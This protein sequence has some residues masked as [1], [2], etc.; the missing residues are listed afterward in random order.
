MLLN[1]Q[2]STY[3]FTNNMGNSDYIACT[4]YLT[5]FS[6]V[7]HFLLDGVLTSEKCKEF[8]LSEVQFCWRLDNLVSITGILSVI[9]YEN[10][11]VFRFIPLPSILS[12]NI[13]N[14]DFSK[15]CVYEQDCILC[16]DLRGRS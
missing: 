14:I 8:N 13:I 16:F 9:C 3:F 2:D 12:L 5:F 4:S 11:F 7:S 15:K 6:P 10:Y 1:L